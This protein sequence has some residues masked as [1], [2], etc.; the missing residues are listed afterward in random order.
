MSQANSVSTKTGIGRRMAIIDIAKP[1]RFE[2]TTNHINLTK[3][4]RS[5]DS[6]PRISPP[7][8]NYPKRISIINSRITGPNVRIANSR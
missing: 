6:L 4:E 2:R 3:S 5:D 1:Y 7:F 8:R